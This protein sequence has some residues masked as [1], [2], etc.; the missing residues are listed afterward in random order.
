MTLSKKHG[1]KILRRRQE[2]FCSQWENETEPH[3]LEIALRDHLPCLRFSSVPLK[4][5]P[6]KLFTT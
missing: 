4:S 3:G 2:D 6:L 5:V 1:E